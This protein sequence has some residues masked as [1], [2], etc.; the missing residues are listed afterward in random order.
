MQSRPAFNKEGTRGAAAAGRRGRS[1][2]PAAVERS[3]DP[4]RTGCSESMLGA[5]PGSDRRR[6]V[7]SIPAVYQNEVSYPEDSLIIIKDL[8]FMSSESQTGR[9]KGVGLKKYLK[10]CDGG[11][12]KVL[13]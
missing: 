8:A 12:R 13:M 2:S 5:V 3:R 11:S 1:L 9:I 4:V 7:D 10:Y 6:L